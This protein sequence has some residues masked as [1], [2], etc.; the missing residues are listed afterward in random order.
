MT[1]FRETFGEDAETSDEGDGGCFRWSGSPVAARLAATGDAAAVASRGAR[2][3]AARVEVSNRPFG[4]ASQSA[5]A[6]APAA[7]EPN[8]RFATNGRRGT[9]DSR[10]KCPRPS[11][12][13][14]RR[15]RWRFAS[16]APRW[17][18]RRIARPHARGRGCGAVV[19]ERARRLRERRARLAEAAANRVESG[20]VDEGI[21]RT[22]RTPARRS[23]VRGADLA[24]GGDV[25]PPLGAGVPRGITGLD[26]GASGEKRETS[27]MKRTRLFFER[28]FFSTKV[29]KK[30]TGTSSRG[31]GALRAQLRLDRLRLCPQRRHLRLRQVSDL[32]DQP[33]RGFRQER[34][35]VFDPSPRGR[36]IAFPSS[37][38]RLSPPPPPPPPSPSPPLAWPPRP[39]RLRRRLLALRGCRLALRRRRRARAPRRAAASRAPRQPLPCAAS[40]ETRTTARADRRR[41]RV[42]SPARGLRESLFVHRRAVAGPEVGDGVFRP[43]PLH[44]RVFLGH[45]G[46]LDVPRAFDLA[47]DLQRVTL[48]RVAFLVRFLFSSKVRVSHMRLHESR[49]RDESRLGVTRGNFRSAS[50]RHLREALRRDGGVGVGST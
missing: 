1:S 50:P 21:A 17:T 32:A 16:R 15:S 28:T 29:R 5:A 31:G 44:T 30:K 25:L 20:G 3:F 9:C 39:R 19:R 24:R 4:S 41:R 14:P 7:R 23:C 6:H 18:M 46:V 38:P 33:L 47:P 12:R 45:R 8:R 48:R 37:P 11:R 49:K 27:K 42:E 34:L 36:R 26:A 22:P 40:T 43:C 13:D 2:R 10:S 35:H